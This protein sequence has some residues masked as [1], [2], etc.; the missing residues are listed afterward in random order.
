MLFFIFISLGILRSTWEFFRTQSWEFQKSGVA[1]LD[2]VPCILQPL[3]LQ[4][5]AIASCSDE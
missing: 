1:A 2:T 4:P 5:A 3:L